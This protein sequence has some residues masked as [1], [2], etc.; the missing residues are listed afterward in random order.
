[1]AIQSKIIF[2]LKRVVA[3]F[4]VILSLT[5]TNEDSLEPV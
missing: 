2:I 1:M 4:R 5:V 3:S